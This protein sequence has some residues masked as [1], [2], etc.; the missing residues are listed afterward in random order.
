GRGGRPAAVAEFV[1]EQL[2]QALGEPADLDLL[3]DYAGDP[4][5]AAGLQVERAL[6][7]LA[8]RPSHEPLRWGVCI[9]RHG[10][11]PPAPPPTAASVSRRSAARDR[12][13]SGRLR[14][15]TAPP[16]SFMRSRNGRSGV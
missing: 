13:G 1:V 4:A 10:P 5:L 3:Q 6:S 2:V 15:D 9:H 11:C 16:V 14:L 12:C 7:G 8:D